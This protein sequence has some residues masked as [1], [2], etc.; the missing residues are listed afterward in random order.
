YLRGV[1]PPELKTTEIYRG[2]LP[3]IGIQ[4]L[5]LLLVILFPE[6]VTGLLDR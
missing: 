4:V 1:A 6:L 5:A 3:F 2:V